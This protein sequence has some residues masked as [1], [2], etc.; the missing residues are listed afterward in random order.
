MSSNPNVNRIPIIAEQV[1]LE[2]M[3]NI[4]SWKV[5]KENYSVSLRCTIKNKEF[6]DMTFK[7]RFYD[8]M[9]TK[10]GVIV[11]TNDDDEIIALS[12][13][14]FDNKSDYDISIDFVD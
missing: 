14:A 7:T 13:F 4:C 6:A 10:F 8:Y 12:W 2:A 3:K 11:Y 9:R 1:M 5:S